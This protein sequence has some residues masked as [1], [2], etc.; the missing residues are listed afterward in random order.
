MECQQDARNSILW[1]FCDDDFSI[2][3][4]LQAHQIVDVSRQPLA[5]LNLTEMNVCNVYRT[6]RDSRMSKGRRNAEIVLNYT[7]ICKMAYK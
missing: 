6:V 5:E 4:D 2:I 1:R 3:H 7:D